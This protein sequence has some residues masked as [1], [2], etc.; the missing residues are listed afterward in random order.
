MNCGTVK[1]WN[2]DR[3]FGFLVPDDGSPDVFVHV[4]QIADT[5][6]DFLEVGAR[7]EFEVGPDSRRSGKTE[8]RNVRVL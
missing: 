7:V 6:H 8:A 1:H 5:G 4:R 2:L 3:G